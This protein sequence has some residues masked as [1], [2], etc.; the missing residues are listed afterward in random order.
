MKAI[1]LNFI[2]MTHLIAL[3]RQKVWKL[4]YYLN[5]EIH[6]PRPLPHPLI[7]EKKLEPRLEANLMH[8]Q[9]FEP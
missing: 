5:H 3:N 8:K 9:D 7:C 4:T 2:C 1:R 6:L